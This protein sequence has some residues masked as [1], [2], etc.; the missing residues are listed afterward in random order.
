VGVLGAP[1]AV[2]DAPGVVNTTPPNRPDCA[3]SCLFSRGQHPF[4][5]AVPGMLVLCSGRRRRV[6]VLQGGR[7]R[8]PFGVLVEEVPD[9]VRR[10]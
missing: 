7:L 5:K 8:G 9:L 4:H 10:L 1:D 2:R 3:V 6:D